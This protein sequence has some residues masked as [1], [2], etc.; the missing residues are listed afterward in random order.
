VRAGSFR[1][2]VHRAEWKSAHADGDITVAPVIA[3]SHGQLRLQIGQLADLKDLLGTNLGGSVQA[4]VVLRPEREAT[5]AELHVDAHDLAAGQ[6]LANAQLT[7]EG[8]TDAAG[9]KLDVQVPELRGAKASLSMAGT[10]N[11]DARKIA[12]ATA[13]A[14]YRGQ[15]LRLLAPS[16]IDL[17][18]GL[19][20]DEVKMGVQEAVLD[21]KGQLSP[22]LDV[23]AS[24]RQVQPSL[25]NV[26][27]PGLLASGTIEAHAEIK[28]SM[29]SPMGQVR[30]AAKDIRMADDAALGLPALDLLASAQLRGDTADVD[31]RLTAGTASKLSVS[32]RAPLAAAGALEL[33]IGGNL[34][35]GMVNP[36]LEARGQHAAGDLAVDATVAGS[37][38]DP[39]IEGTVTLSKG[40]VRDYARGLSLTDITAEIVGSAGTLQIKTMTAKAAPGTV[41]MTGKVGVLQPGIPVELKIKAENAQPLASKLV[42]SNL[43]ADLRVS[44]TARSRLDIAGSLHLNRTLIGIPNSLPPNVAV[45]D[46]RR[47]GKPAPAAPVKQVVI[48]LDIAVQAPQ[49]FLV[50]GRGLDAEM[51]TPP[52]GDLHVS[53]TTDAPIVTGRFVLLRGNFSLA[54]A[55]LD[56]SPESSISF[57]GAG[58]KNKIDPTLDFIAKTTLANGTTVNLHISGYADVPQFELSSSPPLGQDEIMAQLMFGQNVA[59][60]SA[61]QVA[62]IGA[63]L[64]TLSG[65]GGDGG[66]NPL[67]KIQKSLGLDRLT[68]GSGTTTNTG[69]GTENSGA[70]IAAGRYISKRIYVEAKQTTQGT[71][72][73]QTDVELTKHL[74][75]QTRLGN[76]T[77]SVQGATPENDPGSSIG[78]VYQ[79]EY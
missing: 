20:V 33:K 26:F 59:Q 71:T 60:L 30:L 10:L 24:L 76:G 21:L 25:I 15:D 70:S 57:D 27:A 14:N 35:V 40:S 19:S 78:L 47:H 64:A 67:V 36:L 56:F 61:L 48:G 22:T 63:A 34:D 66:L 11:L 18:N 72:Q 13:V 38:A 50:Q 54:N 4:N 52:G 73:L 16:R 9:F 45:L 68:V 3:Q 39:Q 12:V 43:N 37:V 23:S 17:A 65:V 32:G 49:E 8:V 69:T 29:A 51:G 53:G 6:F 62:Q 55:K 44:G 42:T 77:A 2:S 31:G 58:L 75:L 5:H 1:A 28:G 79:I 41:S 46:V 7:A 74:K